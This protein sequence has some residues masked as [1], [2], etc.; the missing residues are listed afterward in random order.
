MLDTAR[1]CGVCIWGNPSLNLPA[2]FAYRDGT[3]GQPRAFIPSTASVRWK[4]W[5]SG[6]ASRPGTAPGP[7]PQ[8]GA[9][10]PRP[11][12]RAPG[13]VL[14]PLGAALRG[15]PRGSADEPRASNRA[16]LR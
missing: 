13:R 6:S 5:I 12:G 16:K 8:R 14:A 3:E 15:S 11:T 10:Q 2:R 1:D 9:P 7:V 4:P